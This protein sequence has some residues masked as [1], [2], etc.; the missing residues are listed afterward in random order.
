MSLGAARKSACAT[1]RFLTFGEPA[2]SRELPHG[3]G[4]VF[5]RSEP[6]AVVFTISVGAETNSRYMLGALA[7]GFVDREN[8]GLPYGGRAE[9]L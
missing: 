6:P 1:G 7:F 5:N 3:H 2:G 8:E 9:R 4:S